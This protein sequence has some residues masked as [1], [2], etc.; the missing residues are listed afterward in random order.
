MGATAPDQSNALVAK[1][2]LLP[3]QKIGTVALVLNARNLRNQIA[4]S[5]RRAGWKSHQTLWWRF[6]I[7]GVTSINIYSCNGTSAAIQKS[8]ESATQLKVSPHEDEGC[9]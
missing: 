3:A 9:K 5:F 4:D 8:I 2:K 7:D 6:S 1:L